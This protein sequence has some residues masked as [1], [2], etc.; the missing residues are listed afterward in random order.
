MNKEKTVNINDVIKVSSFEFEDALI[1]CGIGKYNYVLIIIS[2]FLMACA[3]IELTSVNL[4]LPIATCDLKLS[5]SDKGILGSIGYVGV[6]L[7]SFFWGFLSDV[8]GRKTVLIP[9]LISAFLMSALSS[10]VNSF[11]LL[12]F[13]RFLN[14]FL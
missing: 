11:W 1:K 9:T 13:F 12:S 6:I 14:G 8:K 10:L 7:S 2:G 3:F 5:T 4:I